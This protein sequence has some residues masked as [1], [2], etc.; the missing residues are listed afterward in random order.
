MVAPNPV[1]VGLAVGTGVICAGALAW[2]NRENIADAWDAS[3]DWVGDKAE[4]L[5]NGIASGA[6][7]WASFSTPSTRSRR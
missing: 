5:G 1:T 6:S 3:T 4:D 7:R 2:E